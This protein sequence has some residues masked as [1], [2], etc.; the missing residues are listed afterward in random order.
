MRPKFGFWAYSLLT[1]IRKQITLKFSNQDFVFR[2]GPFYLSKTGPFL[3][4]LVIGE[5]EEHFKD[6]GKIL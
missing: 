3:F 6:S 5:N 2:A 1:A 4:Y